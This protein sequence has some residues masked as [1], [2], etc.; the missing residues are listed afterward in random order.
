MSW[1]ARGYGAH[2][3]V[4]TAA[5]SPTWYFA[6]GA[7]HS[8]F[9]LFYL[10]ENPNATA[11]TV[12]ARYLTGSGATDV[13]DTYVVPPRTRL[14][15]WANWVQGLANA[16]VSAF[17]TTDP[18]TPIVVERTMYADSGGQAMGAG[19]AAAGVT[20]PEPQWYFAEGATG[21][22]FDLF[23]LLANP[24]HA[25]QDVDVTYLLPDGTTVTKHHVVPARRRLTV[26]VDR[27][28]ARLAS[29]AV[30]MKVA[31]PGGAILAERAMWWPGPAGGSWIEGHCAAGSASTATRWIVPDGLVGGD[32]D[33]ET[34]VLVGNPNP[35]ATDVR[36]T[37]VFED[38]A[39]AE[40][41]LSVA[42]ESRANIAVATWL[43]YLTDT[44][45]VPQ[46]TGI[47]TDLLF[48]RYVL[49][50][51]FGMI[52][53]SALPVVVESSTYWDAANAVDAITTWAAGTASV[54][55]R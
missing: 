16:D 19:H 32:R 17:F 26:W 39:R 44:S 11:A 18:A 5:P 55:A 40:T 13:S 50:A 49:G 48:D 29:T 6:E 8:G 53:E 7:T 54:A 21:S 36:A 52:V 47:P 30:A 20:R 24:G 3:E 35:G 45:G 51:R 4:A 37:L 14:T 42:G 27:E 12:D 33:A 41:T 25:D 9:Q 28:D 46:W 43:W 1:N 23:L 34:Y 10:I 2:G 31:A 15:V 38:G 22:Y